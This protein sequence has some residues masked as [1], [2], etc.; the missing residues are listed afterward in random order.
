VGKNIL[1]TFEACFNRKMQDNFIYFFK[2]KKKCL[3]V[4]TTHLL[5]LCNM[6]MKM[7]K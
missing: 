6:M 4:C 7:C 2:G 3:M 5:A 1:F